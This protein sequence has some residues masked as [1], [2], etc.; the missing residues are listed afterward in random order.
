[1]GWEIRTIRRTAR[2]RVR[3]HSVRIFSSGHFR[4]CRHSS[5]GIGGTTGESFR[6]AKKGRIELKADLNF[7]STWWDQL[8]PEQQSEHLST[9][10]PPI[11]ETS[12]TYRIWEKRMQPGYRKRAGKASNLTPEESSKIFQKFQETIKNRTQGDGTPISSDDADFIIQ[13]HYVYAEGPCICGSSKKFLECCGKKMFES[14][15]NQK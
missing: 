3:Q 9:N 14:Q 11:V 6:K 13:Q 4:A 7:L 8:T 15:S 5:T 2:R 1:M 10:C 12:H